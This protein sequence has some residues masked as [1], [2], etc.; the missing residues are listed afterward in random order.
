MEPKKRGRKPKNPGRRGKKNEDIDKF[1]IRRFRTYCRT[2]KDFLDKA[3]TDEFWEWF[4]SKE[5]EPGKSNP[6]HKS[7]SKNH[8]E[9]LRKNREFTTFMREWYNIEGKEEIKK[10]FPHDEE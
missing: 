10:K 6:Y 7:Y 9:Y 8:R 1:W 4:V 5:A 3:S 2:H